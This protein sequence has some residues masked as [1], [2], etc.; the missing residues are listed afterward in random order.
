MLRE[1]PGGGLEPADLEE[2]TGELGYGY[3]LRLP[4]AG[5][6]GTFHVIFRDPDAGAVGDE[7]EAPEPVEPR[8]WSAYANHPLGGRAADQLVPRL[9]DYLRERLPEAM[10]PAAFVVLESLPLSSTGKLDR[11]ALPVPEPARDTVEAPFAAPRSPLEEILAGIWAE[12]L[13]LEQVG[14]D[15]HFF[16]LGGHSLLA[17]QVVTR[18]ER[19]FGVE[20]PLRAVFED[21]TVARL[22]ERIE[23][24]L[25]GSRSASQA[26]AIEPVP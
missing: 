9:R 16:E 8:P 12:V 25:R 4:H 17:T 18:V 11:R 2:L 22:A 21:L 10:V 13:D 23:G 1:S 24:L 19:S 15:D 6:T 7:P 5:S 20:L 14:I 3:D 26:P